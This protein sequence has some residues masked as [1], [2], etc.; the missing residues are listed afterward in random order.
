[1]PE[2]HDYDGQNAILVV[3][4]IRKLLMDSIHPKLAQDG[5]K[6]ARTGA[7]SSFDDRPSV[8]S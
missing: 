4:S 3:R 5:I 8:K 2:K 7:Y 6:K 1:M